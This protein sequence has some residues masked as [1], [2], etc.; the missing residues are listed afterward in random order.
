[1][2]IEI[3]SRRF[4]ETCGSRN[5][6]VGQSDLEITAA[7]DKPDRF[8]AGTFGENGVFV[9]GSLKMADDSLQPRLSS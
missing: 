8:G 2:V 6:R 4:N 5:G 9:F 1:L 7:A 3:C